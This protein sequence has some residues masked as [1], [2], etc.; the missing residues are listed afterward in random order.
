[1]LQRKYMLILYLSET[2]GYSPLNTLTTIKRFFILDFFY[3]STYFDFNIMKYGVFQ[4]HRLLSLLR[5]SLCAYYLQENWHIISN[6][7]S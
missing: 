2:G 4:S 6:N 5:S 7:H 1:M 3:T